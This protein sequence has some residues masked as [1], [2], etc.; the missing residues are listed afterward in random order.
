M[1]SIESSIGSPTTSDLCSSLAG[2]QIKQLAALV[3]NEDP[4]YEESEVNP[5]SRHERY[6]SIRK[7]KPRESFNIR[8]FVNSESL[9]ATVIPCLDS[10]DGAVSTGSVRLGGY[11]CSAERHRSRRRNRTSSLPSCFVFEPTPKNGHVNGSLRLDN[12]RL[13][14]R[15]SPV[16]F[17]LGVQRELQGQITM[18][19][20]DYDQKFTSRK[21]PSRR[22]TVMHGGNGLLEASTAKSAT[23]SRC[24]KSMSPVRASTVDVAIED[25]ATAINNT[26]LN[27]SVATSTEATAS[28]SWATSTSRNSSSDWL[29][30]PSYPSNVSERSLSVAK[31]I[32]KRDLVVIDRNSNANG[33]LDVSCDTT[34]IVCGSCTNRRRS[35][36]VDGHCS[37]L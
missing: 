16:A 31:D 23:S 24:Y 14:S 4:N 28:T 25:V 6:R 33:T 5:F 12:R 8:R 3:A 11:Q 32:R 26:S 9:N 29:A 37:I 35:K 7:I 15:R 13:A 18:S 1:E 34:T 30:E 20:R 36:D 2:E 19:F 17:G 10:T 27:S 21:F 22:H